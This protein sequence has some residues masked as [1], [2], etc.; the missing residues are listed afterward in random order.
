[1]ACLRGANTRSKASVREM[2]GLS[3][4]G[5]IYAETY[6]T[7]KQIKQNTRF[8]FK[9]PNLIGQLWRTI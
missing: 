1:M 5:G 3:A 2:T 7:H 9:L 6:S 4:V 8:D